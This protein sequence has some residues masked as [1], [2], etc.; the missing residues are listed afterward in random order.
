MALSPDDVI[1]KSFRGSRLRRGYD[2]AEV[3]AFLEEVVA[4]LRRLHS[5][6][7][8]LE[9]TAARASEPEHVEALRVSREREQLEEIRTERRELVGELGAMQTQLEQ[10]THRLQHTEEAT[11]ELD[12]LLAESERRLRAAQ[13]QESEV[14]A[15]LGRVQ[16]DYEDLR[17]A[18]EGLVSE[19][20]GIRVQAEAEASDVLG[21]LPSELPET[22]NGQRDDIQ[23]ISVLARQMHEHQVKEGKRTADQL[24]SEA[25]SQAEAI[26]GAARAE[27][28]RILTQTRSEA[29]RM[30]T[31]ARDEAESIVEEAT[32]DA[33]HMRDTAQERA[34]QTLSASRGEAESLRTSG[35]EEHDRLIA[36]AEEQR[37][38]VL[39][40]LQARRAVLEARIAELAAL[41]TTSR[42]HLREVLREQLGLLDDDTR[43][44][45]EP[46]R[47]TPGYR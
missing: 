14:A 38:G 46:G 9:T 33:R 35:R 4:E 30:I 17:S 40:D 1:R 5:Y 20:R 15:R 7:S 39:G 34:E 47:T 8:E 26:D 22:G 24:C 16:S 12:A 45:V 43:W 31:D 10:A 13:G 21:A 23:V 37:A 3:D 36:E 44:S 27:S 42:G 41:L 2:E 11:R 25:R 29:D 28:D 32:A 19:L 18:F 6:A